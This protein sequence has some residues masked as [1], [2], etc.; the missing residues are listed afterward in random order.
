M[1]SLTYSLCCWCRKLWSTS[2]V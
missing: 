2:E 1:K